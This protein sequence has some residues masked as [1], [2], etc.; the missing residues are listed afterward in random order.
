VRAV[1]I[2]GEPPNSVAIYEQVYPYA[3]SLY[4]YTLERKTSPAAKKFI[5]Y[6]LSKDGPRIITKAG[7][8]PRLAAPPSVSSS[9]AP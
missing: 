8:V 2:N 6:A 1:L 7:F 4:L 3:N 5:R 9:L